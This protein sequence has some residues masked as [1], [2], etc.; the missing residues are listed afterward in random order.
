MKKLRTVQDPI[1]PLLVAP[2]DP[3]HVRLQDQDKVHDRVLDR[4]L[5]DGQDLNPDPGQDLLQAH[6]VDLDRDHPQD[7]V[8][9]VLLVQNKNFDPHDLHEEMKSF[10]VQFSISIEDSKSK[11]LQEKLLQ[12]SKKYTMKKIFHSVMIILV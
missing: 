2:D 1:R 3:D 5:Q 12:G 11:V 10:T 4:L 8:P 6:E 9:K 7:H